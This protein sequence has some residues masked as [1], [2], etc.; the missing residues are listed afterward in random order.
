MAV[1][2]TKEKQANQFN[3]NGQLK[4]TQVQYSF[5]ADGSNR[6]PSKRTASNADIK[7]KEIHSVRDLFPYD[8]NLIFSDLRKTALIT[9]FIIV[10]LLCI[11]WYL[12]R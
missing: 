12:K 11:T 6:Q 7:P 4:L 8:V 9:A 2:R 5:R 3:Q 10:I 1:R